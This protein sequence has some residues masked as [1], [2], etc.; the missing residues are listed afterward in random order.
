MPPIAPAVS[1]QVT[2][3]AEKSIKK[4]HPWVYAEAVVKTSREADAGDIAA[5]FSSKREF[6]ALGLFDPTSP[7]RIRILS[8]K[9]K[10]TIDSEWLTSAITSALEKRQKLFD[11]PDTDGF[12]LL[13]GENDNI[14][15]LVADIY[16]NVLVI[17]IDTAGWVPHIE[18]ICDI[19]SALVKPETTVLRLS[20]TI[21]PTGKY[22]DGA[23]L[24]GRPVKSA[25]V[26][27]ENGLLFEADPVNGQKT[28]FFLDQRENRAKAGK[29]AKGRDVLNIFAYNGGF[30]LYAAQGGARSVISLDIAPQA[31]EA[32]KRNFALNPQ[33]AAK[34]ET[35]CADAFEAMKHMADRGRKFGMVIVDP[36]SF[37]RKQADIP[38]ALAAY[39]KLTRLGV[40]L[41]DKDGIL[42]SASCSARV[43]A[44][45]FFDA[46]LKTVRK[47]G[48]K[49]TEID[50]TLNAP[51]HPVG[52]AEGAYLKCIYI[53][54]S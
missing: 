53:R 23:I 10:T 15:G 52:F 26:F 9:P 32:A 3:A 40:N 2:P 18:L 45:D 35:I 4:G 5:I 49:I 27:S 28:G 36:P 33:L 54:L 43:S 17:K 42:I 46:V 50:R 44:E 29:L 8:T 34:H 39:E 30:S 14:P 1:V 37:A 25:V 41:T 11:D 21:E 6:V 22:S 13:H 16:R 48:R 38:N 51:D 7:I 24:R 31:L 47:S 12:R 19:F 20:R